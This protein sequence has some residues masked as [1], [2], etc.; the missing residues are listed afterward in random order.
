VVTVD[1]RDVIDGRAGDYRG[2]RGYLVP[3]WGSVDIDG[4]RVSQRE[5]AAFRFSSVAD[6]Y[7]A[8]TGGGRE[9]G[10]VGVATFPEPIV[11]RPRPVYVPRR[12]GP[13]E[14]DDPSYGPY[15]GGGYG[16]RDDAVGR[17]RE[18]SG[19]P[20]PAARSTPSTSSTGDAAAAEQSAP[21]GSVA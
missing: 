18:K 5:A 14:P 9:G 7:A 13:T 1:G 17:G 19:A 6:S 3:A 20:A 10:V 8:R 21:T 12:T 11:P 16:D 4:W 15:G 2:K